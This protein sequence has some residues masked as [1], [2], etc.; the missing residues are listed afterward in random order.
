MKKKTFLAAT[1]IAFTMA[2]CSDGNKETT[3]TDEH[4]HHEGMA[5][6]DEM[7]T[8][9]KVVVNAPDY[10]SVAEPVK[11]NVSQLLDTYLKLKDAL[12]ASDGAAAKVAASELL[13]QAN[14]MPVATLQADQKTFAEEKIAEV[15]ESA[16]AIAATDDVEAQRQHLELLS[17]ATFSLTK[18]FGAAGKTLYYQHCPM[19][20]NNEGGYWL[21]T[22]KEIRNPYF[23][24]KMMACGSNEEVFE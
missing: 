13:S 11:R 14:A 12:V 15:K 16:T 10:S 23:G 5:H 1:L 8:T 18:A 7:P 21:S 20:K 2:A 3:S 24:D 17:E 9:G 19:A 6:G 4:A 22:Q